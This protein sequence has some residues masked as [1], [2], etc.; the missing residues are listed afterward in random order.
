MY[1]AIKNSIIDVF[2]HEVYRINKR[3]VQIQLSG[4]FNLE[5]CGGA[6]HFP[7]KNKIGVKHWKLL[8]CVCVP[9]YYRKVPIVPS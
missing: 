5:M 6:G 9:W 7:L 8:K 4:K 1:P 2:Q 3:R